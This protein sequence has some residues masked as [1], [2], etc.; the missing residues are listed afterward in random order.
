MIR[1]IF[2]LTITLLSSTGF[3]QQ[4]NTNLL[5][6]GVRYGDASK[7]SSALASGIYLDGIFASNGQSPLTIATQFRHLE[8][9]RVLLEN[10]ASP[11]LPDLNG[12]T[13]LFMATEL[14]LT[15]IIELLAEY[16]CE[17]DYMYFEE[18]NPLGVAIA[19][20]RLDS[21]IALVQ[22][23]A[24]P[25]HLDKNSYSPLA[26]AAAAGKSQFVALFLNNGADPNANEG[27]ALLHAI[28]RGHPDT[29]KLII[30]QGADVNQIFSDG[31]SPLTLAVKSGNTEALRI[32]LEA[33]ADPDKPDRHQN[34]AIA[35]AAVTDSIS[36]MKIL[37]SSGANVDGRFHR[38]DTALLISVAKQ[39][40][41]MI[42]LLVSHCA[43]PGLENNKGETARTWAAYHGD[44]DVAKKIR[45]PCSRK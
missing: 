45:T 40:V 38:G 1:L 24:N 12:A 34:T 41:D 35:S 43:D 32:L 18:F 19:N 10:G 2:A 22:V 30:D 26:L 23:G 13:A 9:V 31:Y 21:A 27:L 8:I 42:N 15:K 14:G 44:E 11:E 28:G 4:D 3:S 6:E 36:A 33:G 17:L 5:L 29:A 20:D 16:D 39:N 37:L 25:N 7:V